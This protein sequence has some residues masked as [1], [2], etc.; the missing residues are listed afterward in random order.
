MADDKLLKRTNTYYNFIKYNNDKSGKLF[1]HEYDEPTYVTV[2]VNFFP[3]IS[4]FNND[5]YN[6]GDVTDS[7]S[8]NSIPH[9]LLTKPQND[10]KHIY[11]TIKYL[12]DNLGDETRAELL[13]KFIDGLIDLNYRCPYYIKSVTGL[14]DLLKVDPKRGSR[15][16]KDGTIILKCI[17]GLDMRISALLNLYKKVAWDDVYQRWILPD[18]MRF[19]K[20]NILISEFRLFGNYKYDVSTNEY[21][22]GDVDSDI[23]LK[24]PTVKYECQMCE[25]D[26]SDTISHFNQLNI[27]KINDPLNDIEIRIK[28]GNVIEHDT[29]D[30]F[31]SSIDIDD[32]IISKYKKNSNGI[33][34]M[35][36]NDNNKVSFYERFGT[37]YDI[38]NHEIPNK[39]PNATSKTYLDKLLSGTLSNYISRASNYITDEIKS[40]IHTYDYNIGLT[41]ADIISSFSADNIEGIIYGLKNRAEDVS[42]LYPE[43]TNSIATSAPL[44]VELF[45]DALK[46]IVNSGATTE[47]GEIFINGLQDIINN[48]HPTLE[49]Y[50]DDMKSFINDYKTLINETTNSMATNN[51]IEIKHV[52]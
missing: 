16:I 13:E 46:D 9:P 15:V 19:F 49:S 34:N 11:S 5:T 14:N 12:R 18:I 35:P 39:I 20:M 52:L 21:V 48:N 4:N 42:D 8:Y 30:L 45:N 10:K 17:E 23:N 47:N 44:D 25:F 40:F 29:Y 28:V 32:L 38:M 50:I 51:E 43:V 24:I 31:A 2:R 36:K 3:S 27:D 22:Q 6:S 26:I 7:T 33:I 41:T 37:Q 1:K